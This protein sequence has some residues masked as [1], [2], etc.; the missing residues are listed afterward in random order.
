MSSSASSRILMY[1][2][3]NELIGGDAHY[4]FDLINE[5]YS[6]G[7]KVELVTDQNKLFKDR[8]DAWLK[9]DLVP[10]YLDTSPKLFKP[11]FIEK[12]YSNLSDNQSSL[13]IFQ[14]AVFKILSY[15]IG[16]RNIAGY[17]KI[18]MRVVLLTYVR[19][20]TSNALVFYRVFKERRGAVDV[21]HF[22][23]GG[24]P[25]KVAGVFGILMAKCFKVERIVMT[26]HNIPRKRWL[27]IDVLCDLIVRKC[28]TDIITASDRV[29]DELLANRKIPAELCRTIRCGLEDISLLG[30]ELCLRKKGEL[31]VGHHQ[32]ILLISGNYEEERKGHVPLLRA[33]GKVKKKFPNVLLLIVGGGSEEKKSDLETL[34]ETLGISENVRMLGYRRDIYELNSVAD[35]C[36]TPSVGDES[37][38]YTIIEAARLGRPVITTTVGGCSEAVDDGRTGFVVEPYDIDMLSERIE[39][40]L[41]SS[42]L[43]HEMGEK[44]R[45]LFLSRFLLSS[46]IEEHFP[47][48]GFD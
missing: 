4:A 15:S 10:G 21:F 34:I 45:E 18:F 22:N 27:P 33:I 2:G 46:R 37:I 5:L 47:A 44:S 1:T 35:V 12:F 25:A 41:G 23:N 19:A 32:P 24:F 7:C 11:H 26:V 43:R 36:L 42:E 31:G 38:P 28:C 29:R 30:S 48:Y 17:L 14:L 6:K 16:S 39:I 40:L 9:V 20:H 8:A 13:T 3:H